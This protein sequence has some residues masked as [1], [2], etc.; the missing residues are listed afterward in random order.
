MQMAK[1]NTP[2]PT[3]FDK[4]T[5]AARRVFSLPKDQTDNVIKAVPKPRKKSQKKGFH[6]GK[7]K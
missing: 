1:E 6:N 7:T 3:P 5:E 4:F 2:H